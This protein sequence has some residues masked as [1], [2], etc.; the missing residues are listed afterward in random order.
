MPPGVYISYP[1]CAQKCS[2]CN[3]ASDVFPRG[4]E[5]SYLD[6]L[7]RE[8]ADTVWPATPDTVY[9][10]GGTPSRMS[11]DDL[12]R[13]LR[14]IPGRPWVEATIE[15]A[16]GTLTR[17]GLQGWREAGITRV[18]LGVQSFDR[19][20]LSRTG[21]KHTAET[22]LADVEMLREAGLGNFNFD[23]IAGLS[24]QTLESWR[25]SLHW[26]QRIDPP[27]VSIYM[28][29]VDDDSRLGREVLL[30]GRRYGAPE[31][32]PDDAVAEFYEV[33]VAHLKAMGLHRYEISNFSKAGFESA[34]NLKYW[35]LEP[36][37]GFG[38]DA[39][40]FDGCLR[41]QNVEPPS[42]YVERIRETGAARCGDSASRL[43]EEKFFVGLRLSEGI[44]P[45]PEEW[46]QWEPAISRFVEEGLLEQNGERLKLTDRGVLYSN[47]V[48]VEFVEA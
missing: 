32:P 17:E 31:V 5:E 36:Y 4:F 47:E 48:L 38:A 10:G 16:P 34:H 1:I 15:A 30:N 29:E 6:A 44:A 24:G 41:W 35:R 2:F 33:G 42:E 8:I 40:S 43:A 3:F 21:R 12:S 46:R 23:L 19:T 25:H 37:V 11:V 20:E 9:I 45:S 14:G 39:H 28:L 22:V 7:F 26:V 13:L 27:H 18:S